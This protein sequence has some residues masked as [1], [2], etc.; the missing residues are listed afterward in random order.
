V[1]G[2][3]AFAENVLAL[4]EQ[5]FRI[6]RFGFRTPGFESRAVVELG[7]NARVEH[8]EDA[9]LVQPHARF[10]RL[11]FE[12]LDFLD[13]R[14]VVCE[15]R[16]TRVVFAGHQRAADEQL[17]RQHRI[18]RAVVDLAPRHQRDA[19]Q[20]HAL[21]RHHA[22]AVLF[23]VRL[24]EHAGQQVTP[25]ASIHSGRTSATVRASSRPVSVSSAAM[26]HFG[27]FFASA[28]PG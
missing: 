10:A 22:R 25:G 1:V 4:Q 13:Q 23:P 19:V 7:R 8:A 27:P 21:E 26:I 24:D 17:A 14:A 2:A 12:L 15:P 3:E 11:V 28:E 9:F 5:D 6:G 18:D 16:R 20:A